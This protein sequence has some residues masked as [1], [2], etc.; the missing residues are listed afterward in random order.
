ME[1]DEEDEEHRGKSV[2]EKGAAERGKEVE[3][4]EEEDGGIT[5]KV[6]YTSTPEERKDRKHSVS[7]LPVPPL[8]PTMVTSPSSVQ[9]DI[10]LTPA[11]Q[12]TSSHSSQPIP[13]AS[14]ATVQSQSQ[15]CT[16]VS[17]T[18]SCSGK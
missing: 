5:F 12:L 15:M 9:S 16:L 11:L 14:T 7:P 18:A 13:T 1:E 6:R 17:T 2:L 10:C 4:E 8:S 3:D